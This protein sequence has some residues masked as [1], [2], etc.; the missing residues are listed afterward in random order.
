MI[1]ISPIS[2]NARP[3]TISSCLPN[4]SFGSFFPPG[5]DLVIKS[6]VL[7]YPHPLL[8]LFMKWQQPLLY[9]EE[10][11]PYNRMEKLYREC[12]DLSIVNTLLHVLYLFVYIYTSQSTESELQMSW[13]LT[14]KHITVC[15]LRIMLFSYKPPTTHHTYYLTLALRC[16]PLLYFLI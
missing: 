14:L 11:Q 13:P 16:V 10:V 7:R 4:T 5:E 9:F 1:N 6:L 12:L 8:F 2:Y 3:F 15:L